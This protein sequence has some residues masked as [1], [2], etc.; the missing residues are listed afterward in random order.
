MNNLSDTHFQEVW[1]AL[2]A[3]SAGPL[4]RLQR[5]AAVARTLNRA[6]EY[7]MNENPELYYLQKT[8]QLI[9]QELEGMPGE[10]EAWLTYPESRQAAA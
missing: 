10:I 9:D 6:I 2:D 5:I 1:R 3:D 8:A 4:Q 7:E